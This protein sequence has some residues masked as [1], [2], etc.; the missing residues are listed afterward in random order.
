[1]ARG[2]KKKKAIRTM[3]TLRD[4]KMCPLKICTQTFIAALFTIA[5]RVKTAQIAIRGQIKQIWSIQTMEYY[6]TIKRKERPVHITT[7]MNLEDTILE[8]P[9]PKR[10]WNV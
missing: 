3:A 4:E 10:S 1:M 7:H 6:S 5:K 8:K 9:G 2:Q